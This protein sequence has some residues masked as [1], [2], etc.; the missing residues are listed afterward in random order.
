MVLNPNSVSAQNI[1]FWQQI[2]IKLVVLYGN[3][4]PSRIHK[5]NV[6]IRWCATRRSTGVRAVYLFGSAR[7]KVI[8]ATVILLCHRYAM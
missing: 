1:I 3:W 5:L 4:A 8:V 6:F 7:T 2:H